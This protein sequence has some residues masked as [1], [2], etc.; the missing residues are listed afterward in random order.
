MGT[1]IEQNIDIIEE[2]IISTCRRI[3]GRHKTT[4]YNRKKNSV[5]LWITHLTAVRQKVDAN[6]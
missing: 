3:F 5:P 1:D 2:T 6:S 4:N